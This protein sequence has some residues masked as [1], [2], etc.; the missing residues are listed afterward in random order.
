ML[1]Q[2]VQ[3]NKH[4]FFAL[5]LAAGVFV[6]G[7]TPAAS[8]ASVYV[9]GPVVIGSSTSHA[10]ACAGIGQLGGVGCGGQSSLQTTIKNLINLFSAIVGIAAIVMIIVS[11]FKYITSQGDGN[12]VH[13]ARNTLVYAVVGLVVVAMAQFIVRFVLAKS[14]ATG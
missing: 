5:A 4:T 9:P 2:F 8:A 11:G 12:A 7:I 10:D 13:T 14:G 3:K 6:A 1:A